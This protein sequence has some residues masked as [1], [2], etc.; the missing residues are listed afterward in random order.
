MC[1]LFTHYSAR[2]GKEGL[3]SAFMESWL[4]TM[5]QAARLAGD[6]NVPIWVPRC[7]V[8]CIGMGIRLN[9]GTVAQ[10]RLHRRRLDIG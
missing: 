4:P 8:A 10:V 9:V 3:D 1:H 6:E 7:A 5:L 2:C